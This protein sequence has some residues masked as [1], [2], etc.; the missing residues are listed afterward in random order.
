[1]SPASTAVC[2]PKNEHGWQRSPTEPFSEKSIDQLVLSISETLHVLYRLCCQRVVT[3][4]IEARK[5]G[6]M[7]DIDIDID[8]GG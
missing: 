3:S 5:V 6:M 7:I 2:G 4:H 8:M 1:V